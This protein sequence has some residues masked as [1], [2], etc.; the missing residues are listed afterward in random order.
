MYKLS[1]IFILINI[2]HFYSIRGL[3][4]SL[5]LL[6]IFLYFKFLYRYF[7]KSYEVGFCIYLG[8]F[9]KILQFQNIYNE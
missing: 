4:K 5:I 3:M 6:I 1:L 7:K 9:T 8:I 2:L